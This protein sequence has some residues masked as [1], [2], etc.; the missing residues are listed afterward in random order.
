MKHKLIG[1]GVLLLTSITLTQCGKDCAREVCDFPPI[2]TFSFRILNSA[3]LDMLVGPTKVYDTSQVKI[4]ARRNGSASV[5][6]I[7]RLFFITK[8]I[9]G[10]A[11]SI[12][13]TGFTVNRNYAVYYLSLNNVVTDSLF[14][15][16][17]ARNTTCCDLSYYFF[18]KLNTSEISGGLP[19]PITN[20]YAIRK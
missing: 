5:E 12:A 20:G 11:D 19:L 17:A 6:P 15:G 1:L 9:A 16:Y 13:T 8:N 4:T 2:P 18:S 10:T 3:N 7:N 14:F